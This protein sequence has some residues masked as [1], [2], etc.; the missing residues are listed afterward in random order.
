MLGQTSVPIAKTEDSRK[1]SVR[2][3]DYSAAMVI[4]GSSF[5]AKGE[6]P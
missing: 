1:G 2:L 5:R 4:H 3:L 6:R